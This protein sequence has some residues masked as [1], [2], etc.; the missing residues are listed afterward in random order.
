MKSNQTETKSKSTLGLTRHLLNRVMCLGAVILT[1]SSAP[2]QNLF[3]SDGYSNSGNIY[4]FTPDGVQST[5]ASGLSGLGGLAFDSAGNLFVSDSTAG[6]GGSING[7]IYKFTPD[8]ARTTF[9]LGL[10]FPRALAFNRAG[11]LFVVDGGSNRILKFTPDGVRTTFASGSELNTTTGLACDSAGN[12]FVSEYGSGVKGGTVNGVPIIYK[13]APSGVRTTFASPSEL[14]GPTALAFDSTGNLFVSD[15]T[16]T[17]SSEEHT[18]PGAIYKF[19]PDGQRSTFTANLHGFPSIAFQP[20]QTPTSTPTP[21]PAPTPTPSP[22]PRPSTTPTPSPT[23]TPTPTTGPAVMLIPPPGSTFTSSSVTFSWSAGSATAYFL[24]VGSSPN[25][26]DIYNS[27]IVTVH[28][29][30]VNNIPTD[31]RTIY[32]TLLSEVNNSWTFK[33]Y[34]YKAF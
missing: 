6:L 27:G 23:P 22:T 32:A 28:S 34:T 9:A 1:C 20:T 2:A 25:G 21:T 8:G 13:F 31:G 24:L 16:V 17:D 7:T 15:N 4:K 18:F 5:F 3:V 30:T 29:K 11:D 26:A 12:L 14:N 10:S 19:T 33:S